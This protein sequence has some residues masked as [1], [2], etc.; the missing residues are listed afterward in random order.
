MGLAGLSWREENEGTGERPL[1]F[2]G[3]GLGQILG[4][5]VESGQAWDS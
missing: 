4:G 5:G 3:D 2:R 1:T